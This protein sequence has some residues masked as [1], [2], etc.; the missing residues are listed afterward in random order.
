MSFVVLCG[1]TKNAPDLIVGPFD[2]VDEADEWIAS[3]AVSPGRYAVPMALT[4]PEGRRH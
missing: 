3:Q 4:A 2:T 1:P